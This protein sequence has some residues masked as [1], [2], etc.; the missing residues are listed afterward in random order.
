MKEAE[1]RLKR[2][3]AELEQFAYA[4]S[5]DLREPLR[6]VASFVKLLERRYKGKLDEKADEFIAFT[7]D[8]INRIE[9]LLSD[10][11]EFSRLGTRARN[12]RHINAAVAL[13]KAIYDLGSAIEGSGAKITYDQLPVVVANES[14]IARLFQNLI[15]N[16]IK[17]RG[18]KKPKI[19]VSAEQ[20]ENEWVFSV[21]DN[22]IGIDPQFDKRIFVVFQRLHT[23]QEYEGTGM[24]LSFCKKIVD[25][26]G[27]RIWVESELGKGS[28]FYFTLP[29]REVSAK[30]G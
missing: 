4:A 25:L 5:H 18:E 30:E 6:T 26:H 28:T 17:F 19:H 12:M 24:G 2:S 14:Q 21:R 22:G 11:L 3:N 15:G 29:V 8:G 23:R 16:S 27:G 20:K 13:E 9:A 10:L 7:I 1:E